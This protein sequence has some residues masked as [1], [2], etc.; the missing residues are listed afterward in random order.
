MMRSFFGYG[1]LIN[2]ES[3]KKTLPTPVSARPA[4]ILG[5]KRDFSVWDPIGFTEGMYAGQGIWAMNVTPTGK[6]GRVNGIIFDIEDRYLPALMD[7]EQGYQIIATDAYDYLTHA[8]TQVQLFSAQKHVAEFSF[9]SEA[10]HYYLN[11][12]VEGAKSLGEDFYDEF[13]RTTFVGDKS[14][15][16]LQQGSD[17][18]RQSSKAVT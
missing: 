9:Q 18:S 14:L 2:E 6:G 13:L 3:R 1:S 16:E 7:R 11:L 12:C 17:V 10:Q 15:L 4:Y 5:F 8:P